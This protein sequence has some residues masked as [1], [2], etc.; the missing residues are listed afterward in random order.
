[1]I[2]QCK[3]CKKIRRFGEWIEIPADFVG[4]FADLKKAKR[5]IKTV[6]PSCANRK[7]TA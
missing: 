7:D 6:C 1:M 5:V 4:I 2:H 3:R